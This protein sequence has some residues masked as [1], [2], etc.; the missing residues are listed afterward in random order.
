MMLVFY[1]T[2]IAQEEQD[3]NYL[4]K[5]KCNIESSENN[6]F[7]AGGAVYCEISAHTTE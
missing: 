6:C 3:W 4:L 1:T 5:E 7:E 2:C